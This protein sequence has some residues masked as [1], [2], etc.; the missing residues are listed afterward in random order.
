MTIRL[1]AMGA[2]LALTANATGQALPD[3]PPRIAVVSLQGVYE[4]SAAG[5][6]IATELE[7]LQK[8]FDAQVAE[9]QAQVDKARAA[10]QSLQDE[11]EKQ[12]SLLTE[13]AAETKQ[14]ELRRQ[15]RDLQALA[16]DAQAELQRA[17]ER[18]QQQAEKLKGDFQ[19]KIR[20]FIEAVSKEKSIDLLFEAQAATIGVYGPTADLT[21]DV[22]A[23]VDEAEKSKGAA[24]PKASSS[25][26]PKP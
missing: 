13:D 4:H 7:K 25:S 23:K 10:V 16:Q 14:R 18:V 20:P 9:K 24:E 12:G 3:R 15:N 22:V 19:V 26:R 1:S 21:L 5:K 11:I 8:E 17:R 2:V 6:A